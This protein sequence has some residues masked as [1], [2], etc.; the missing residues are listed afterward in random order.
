MLRTWTLDLAT[1]RKLGLESTGNA[2]RGTGAPPSPAA[3]NLELTPG[4]L[5]REELSRRWAPGSW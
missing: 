1:G 5:S 2:G 3:G 4:R